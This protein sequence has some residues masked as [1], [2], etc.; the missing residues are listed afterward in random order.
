M[1]TDTATGSIVLLTRLARV[2]YRQSTVELV[3]MG[4]KELGALAYLRDNDQ[5]SQQGLF[6]ALCI[7]ANSCVLLL[8]EL[9]RQGYVE[10]R[11]DPQD[12]RRHLVSITADGLGALERAEH[13]QGSI[14]DEVLHGLTSEERGTL[15]R[16]LSHALDGQNGGTDT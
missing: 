14:E 10:R 1:A 11:R 13:A 2:V 12:R 6:E 3:G 7:D 15:H 4:L 9:E 8:N 16:L 5:A